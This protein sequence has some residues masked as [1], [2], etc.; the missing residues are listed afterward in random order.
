MF[1]IRGAL[2]AAVTTVARNFHG[3]V[4]PALPARHAIQ[5]TSDQRKSRFFKQ[6][7]YQW[8]FFYAE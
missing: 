8:Q 4:I 5:K 2:N 3:I 7:I 1:L 6:V